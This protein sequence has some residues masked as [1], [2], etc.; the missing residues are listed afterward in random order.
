MYK[1]LG[2]LVAV[3]ATLLLLSACG[4]K[5]DD[6]RIAIP[7]AS[8]E[9][10]GKNYKAVLDE[11]NTAGFTNVKTA[12]MDDLVLG[13]LTKDGEVENVSI[14]G[15][16][17]FSRGT[18][19]MPDVAIIVTYH[20]FPDTS[21]GDDAQDSDDGTSVDTDG[22]TGKKDSNSVSYSTNNEATVKNGNSG[23]YAYKTIGG[24]HDNYWI[25][26][27]DEQYVYWFTDGNGDLSCDRVPMVSGSLNDVLII[28]YHDGDSE[29]SYGLHFKWKNQPD[30]LIMQDNNGF[31]YEYYTT[32]LKEA[33]SLRESRVISDY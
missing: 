21:N 18:K 4:S 23:V 16:K 7:R 12:V 17:S 3:I 11:L 10:E 27:F 33:L 1:R 22:N 8:S 6:S 20:T 25:I 9:Y 28:T 29:W 14:D 26:D 30:T 31:E 24:K 32:N 2:I 5:D 13:I 15:N 19:F